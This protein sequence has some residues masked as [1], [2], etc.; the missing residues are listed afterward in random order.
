[1]VLN[2]VLICL[3]YWFGTLQIPEYRI[4]RVIKTWE[5]C[6]IYN[7]IA[8]PPITPAIADATAITTFRIISHTD[9][10]IAIVHTPP[11]VFFFKMIS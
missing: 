1:M 6:N 2:R 11:F 10:L 5:L 9:F 4:C 8:L 7:G 3:K